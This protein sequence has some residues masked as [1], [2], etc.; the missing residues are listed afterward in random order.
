MSDTE[1]LLGYDGRM[2]LAEAARRLKPSGLPRAILVTDDGRRPD[3][4]PL[5]DSLPPGSAVLLRHY[6]SPVRSVLAQSLAAI[7]RRRRLLLLVAGDWRLA[8]QV[9][10]GGVHLPEGMARHGCLSPALGWVRR[11]KGLLTVAC[12]SLPALARARRLKA[13]A[14][15]LSPVFSTASHPGAAAIG[16][17]RWSAWVRRAGLPAIA[18]GGITGGS[19]SRLR[20]AP[21]AGLAAVGGW[22]A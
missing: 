13:D 4:L 16:A 12:H 14:A 17:V 8:A 20:L 18:L 11:R 15:L 2:T 19:A 22:T 10:A 1:A 6:A 9:R 5:P 3:P 21:V 7:C